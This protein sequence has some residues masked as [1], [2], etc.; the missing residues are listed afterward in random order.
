MAFDCIV[1]T[2]ALGLYIFERSFETRSV[3]AD[4]LILLCGLAILSALASD[5]LL[6][7][8]DVVSFQW[9]I[10]R[11]SVIGALALYAWDLF[12]AQTMFAEDT[13]RFPLTLWLSFAVLAWS[14][15]TMSHLS[16][17]KWKRYP[18]LLENPTPSA[19]LTP[20]LLF[21]LYSGPGYL[22]A[23]SLVYKF[24]MVM[25]VSAEFLAIVVCVFTSPFS[26]QTKR[27]AE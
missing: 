2:N 19:V 21:T 18:H 17:P 4:R 6:N 24:D 11:L 8:G 23:A 22:I 1:G 7:G 26:V 16:D 13:L 3:F 5:S 12:G 15:I 25:F 10:N 27:P 14:W 9:A 20:I